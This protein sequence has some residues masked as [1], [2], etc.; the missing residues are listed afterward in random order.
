[1]VKYENI[2]LSRIMG[3][4]SDP[5]RRRMVDELVRGERSIGELAEP[6]EM[7]MPAISKHVSIL[8]SVGL[9]RTRREGKRVMCNLDA[10]NLMRVSTWLAKYQRFW[11]GK[12]RELEQNISNIK[13]N[14]L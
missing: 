3:A 13:Q 4:I 1:M 7:S 2:D 6:F 12:L 14:R 5:T 10:E 9:I 8:R 11:E